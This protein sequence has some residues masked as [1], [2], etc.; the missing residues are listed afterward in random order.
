MYHRFEE[1]KYPSTNIRNKIFTEHLKEINN[2]GIEFI[3]FD[4]FKKIINS[5][6]EKNYILLTIDDGFASF[7]LNAWPILKRQKSAAYQTLRNV[8]FNPFAGCKH[9][10]PGNQRQV[11]HL[12]IQRF[13][14]RHR[15]RAELP[16][17][18]DRI[19]PQNDF[20]LWPIDLITQKIVAR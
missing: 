16:G 2:L 8:F 20:P 18:S 3:N 9:L 12:L 5:K 7:Y 13:D 4:K 17:T 14:L 10:G 6:I 19:W 11:P 15:V 1:N